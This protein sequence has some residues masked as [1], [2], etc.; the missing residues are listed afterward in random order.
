MAGEDA[1]VRS[2]AAIALQAARG[3]RAAPPVRA[4][5]ETG[6]HFGDLRRSCGLPTVAA[7]APKRDDP[8]GHRRSMDMR[9]NLVPG[10]LAVC[11]LVSGPASAAGFYKV[12]G[13]GAGITMNTENGVRVWRAA[14]R[15]DLELVGAGPAA[16]APA[17]PSIVIE[18]IAR[19][20]QQ[21]SSQGFWSGDPVG[22]RRYTQGI[23]SGEPVR[24]G[25]TAV[26]IWR[27]PG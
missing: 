18:V 6:A 17:A 5:G 25:R 14:K 26:R 23:Y 1:S 11:A 10:A 8:A 9:K 2:P 15:V 13:A 7:G 22:S 12:G 27:R 16:S 4:R 3:G 19:T 24:R 21:A 20:R